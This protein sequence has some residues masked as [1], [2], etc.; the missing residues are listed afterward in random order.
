MP[1]AKED[2]DIEFDRAMLELSY[3]GFVK[4]PTTG[5]ILEVLK[6]DDKVLCYCG[7]SGPR[8]PKG[9]SERTHTHFVELVEKASV[10]EFIAQEKKRR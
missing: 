3:G 8:E 5:K 4:C 2:T 1:K 6:G 7:K 9:Y 10:D